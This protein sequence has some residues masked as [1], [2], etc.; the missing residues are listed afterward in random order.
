MDVN[1]AFLQA[2]GGVREA[3]VGR[4]GAELGLWTDPDLR[5]QLV[6]QLQRFGRVRDVI[7]KTPNAAGDLR[8]YLVAAE[9][10]RVNGDSLVL[11]VGRDVT[12]RRRTEARMAHLAMHD[13]L[14]GLANRA[15]FQQRLEDGLRGDRGFDVLWLD[16]DRF[17]DVND[18]LGHA[19][20]DELLQAVAGRLRACARAVDTVARLGGDEF[21]VI[22]PRVPGQP[23]AAIGLA[24]RI[25]ERLGQPFSLP[26]CEHRTTASIGL[27]SAP[28]DATD[29]EALLKAADLAL[30]AAKSA[31]RGV[32]RAYSR[33]MAC[34]AEARRQLE[35]G[36]SKAVTG[37]EFELY[38]QP[39]VE[40]RGRRIVG[41]EALLRWR[42]PER[43]LVSP[44]EFI[45]LA[46]ETGLIRA[47]GAWVLRCATAEAASW[48]GRLRVSVNISPAQLRTG[49]LVGEVEAALLASGL[50]P[51]RLELEIT[52]SIL[53]QGIRGGA[54]DPQPL[55]GAGCVAR[56]R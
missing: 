51:D 25:L 26:G 34:A 18:L 20:G 19:V 16:L 40:A 28:G 9:L 45:P 37:G 54:C 10:L 21:A 36:L 1:A 17:K 48:P 29:P 4:T 30:Y 13:A 49:Q 33:D 12:E 35:L 31:G 42:H 43:G 41:F 38:Y 2:Y 15:Q 24:E 14:T 50:S 11:F 32:V 22:I 6:D 23:S 5:A 27:A 55:Q 46:E 7:T 52:E 53:L 8:E 56:A 3:V 44:A 47:I 39:L